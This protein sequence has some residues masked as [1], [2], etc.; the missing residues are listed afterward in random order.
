M[1]TMITMITIGELVA[2]LHDLGL[3][4]DVIALLVAVLAHRV[5]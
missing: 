4:P 1:G 3:T 5:P 2:R